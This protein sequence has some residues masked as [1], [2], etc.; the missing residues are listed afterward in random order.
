MEEVLV[1]VIKTRRD[2]NI[3]KRE[4]WYRVPVDSLPKRQ[5]KYIAFY[6]PE[7]FGKDGKRINYYAKVVRKA[8]KKRIK[9]LPEETSH[10]RA[11]NRYFVFHFSKISKL[12]RPVRNI[13]P[14]RVTFGFT[15][16]KTLFRANDLLELYGVPKTEQI[17]HARLRELGI[18]ALPQYYIS[19]SG[20][21]FRLDF[22]IICRRA[23]LAIECDNKRAHASL[24]QRKKDK[25]KDTALKKL[26]WR[27]LRFREDDILGNLESCEKLI[28]RELASL[29]GQI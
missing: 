22:A 8:K 19:S 2:L 9:I 21:R 7:V 14:R 12:A 10:P 25:D 17:L 5:F 11:N 27:V 18:K 15:K 1:A 4:K 13:I 20:K 6:Q 29:G 24:A 3:L 28:N 16:L 23:A 26:G